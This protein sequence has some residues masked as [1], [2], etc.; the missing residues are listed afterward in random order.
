MRMSVICWGKSSPHDKPTSPEALEARLA[1]ARA[2]IAASLAET[3]RLSK[4]TSILCAASVACSLAA[5][6]FRFWP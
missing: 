3:V 2:T 1:V 6:A 4:I 5:I